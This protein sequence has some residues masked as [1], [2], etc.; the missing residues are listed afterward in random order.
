MILKTTLQNNID[1]VYN[2]IMDFIKVTRSDKF[3]DDY[4]DDP[5]ILD[6]MV[7]DLIR[8]CDEVVIIGS[9]TKQEAESLVENTEF[10]LVNAVLTELRRVT[11]QSDKAE[12]LKKL[13]KIYELTVTGYKQDAFK[14]LNC[15]NSLQSRV[16]DLTSRRIWEDLKVH[17]A[18]QIQE[19]SNMVPSGSQIDPITLDRMKAKV[20]ELYDLMKHRVETNGYLSTI[21]SD[22]DIDNNV[23]QFKDDIEEV[24]PTREHSGAKELVNEFSTRFS[25]YVNNERKS[26]IDET[27][28]LNYT[29][30]GKFTKF[31]PY[32]HT[33]PNIIGCGYKYLLFLKD[34][35]RKT[36]LP[37]VMN[38]GAN[39]IAFD[40]LVNTKDLRKT[41]NFIWDTETS[42]SQQEILPAKEQEELFDDIVISDYNDM[43]NSEIIQPE[44][45]PEPEPEPEDERDILV[46][47]EERDDIVTEEGDTIRSE[48]ANV[49]SPVIYGNQIVREEERD[50]IKTE[51]GLL[52]HEE[53]LSDIPIVPMSTNIEIT[54]EEEQEVSNRWWDNLKEVLEQASIFDMWVVIT[55]QDFSDPENPFLNNVE[56]KDKFTDAM[57]RSEIEEKFYKKL[58]SYIKETKAKVIIN[59]GHGNYINTTDPNHEKYVMY[60]TCGY[61]RKM[62]NYIVYECGFTSNWLGLTANTDQNLYYYSPYCEWYVFDDDN[63]TVLKEEQLCLKD[64]V[65][66]K[67][68]DEDSCVIYDEF[69]NISGGYAKFLISS[70]VHSIP[71][72]N[73]LNLKEKIQK[74]GI[75]IT[76]GQEPDPNIM[77]QIFC[78]NSREA[79]KYF[80]LENY[81][82]FEELDFDENGDTL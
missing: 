62:I 77:K 78:K 54:E 7:N 2:L 31:Y 38:S 72:F 61:L 19:I 24:F 16:T 74:E 33:V 11:I 49:P 45:E 47:E 10:Q 76:E 69:S 51:D 60:P 35:Y 21:V 17:F 40:I 36:I 59:F 50:D 58:L 22:S 34:K 6:T 15:A 3:L 67:T 42:T 29:E 65:D 30:N 8:K 81:F 23:N 32:K 25:D 26:K 1:Q 39:C 9:L 28:I 43:V 66:G 55:L 80:K 48:E 68:N 5:G 56:D 46:R 44:D 41:V 12:I 70:S 64:V 57:W 27:L 37:L 20:E 52:V 73:M 63:E 14:I 18:P 75:E 82:E 13:E 4:A 53:G 79:I 71:I